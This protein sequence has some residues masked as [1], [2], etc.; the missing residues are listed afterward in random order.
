MKKPATQENNP[1][2]QRRFAPV[3]ILP[4]NENWLAMIKNLAPKPKSAPRQEAEKIITRI[5]N[6][7]DTYAVWHNPNDKGAIMNTSEILFY[8]V[9]DLKKWKN[10]MKKDAKAHNHG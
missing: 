2:R 8:T 7:F 10:L 6:R 9:R 4:Q 5:K 3:P 1:K